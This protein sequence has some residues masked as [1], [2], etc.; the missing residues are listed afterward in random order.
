MLW[1][2]GACPAA[3]G[4]LRPQPRP[5]DQ[6]DPPRPW[7]GRPARR[8]STD[9]R[10]NAV[11]DSFTWARRAGPAPRPLPAP[12]ILASTRASGPGSL[13]QPARA[14]VAAPTSSRPPG[15]GLP[16]AW[17]DR[18]S[19]DGN[20]R[21]HAPRRPLTVWQRAPGHRRQPQPALPPADTWAKTSASTAP[22]SAPR[23]AAAAPRSG[24]L[25]VRL[26]CVAQPGV[27]PGAAPRGA[28]LGR[29]RQPL[30][31]SA[32][33]PIR[34][35]GC[36][37]CPMAPTIRSARSRPQRLGVLPGPPPAGAQLALRA[38]PSPFVNDRHRR[39]LGDPFSDRRPGHP[40]P[41]GALKSVHHV[42][43][44][45]F[46]MCP[47]WRGSWGEG[48]PGNHAGVTQGSL[49]GERVGVRGLPRNQP[50][51]AQR[52]LPATPAPRYS[53]A[54]APTGIAPAAFAAGHSPHRFSR[55][56]RR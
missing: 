4:G 18:Q 27:Q 12:T 7:A 56:Q 40:R 5:P 36:R 44:R 48:L 1:L 22:C 20:R 8:A 53:P 37:R 54:P 52:S 55:H 41:A 31:T 35:S 15:Y 26:R 49:L 24:Q 43:E 14:T 30:S 47:V 46:T 21:A 39:L 9:Q 17:V 38:R 34:P 29:A 13:P 16:A 51:V 28:G 32:P 3:A 50:R 6:L 2:A 23:A 10:V 42:S 25:A 45:V 33:G 19:I 11:A